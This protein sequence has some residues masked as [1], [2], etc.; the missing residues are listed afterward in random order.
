MLPP[1]DNSLPRE[2]SPPPLPPRRDTG[3][4]PNTHHS[5]N[6]LPL[7]GPNTMPRLNPTNTSQLH[8][9]RVASLHPH[10]HP[11]HGNVA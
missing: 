9:R 11:I 4:S 3:I 10:L 7:M 6:S 1:R 8:I 2:C 5:Y